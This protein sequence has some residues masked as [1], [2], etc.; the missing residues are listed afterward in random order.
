MRTCKCGCGTEVNKTWAK[1]HH[2]RQSPNRYEVDSDLGCWIWQLH[3]GSNGYGHWK[4]QGEPRPA[5][6]VMYEREVGEIL[7]GREIDHICRNRAC[8]NPE[9]LRVVTH[10]GN[11]RRKPVAKLTMEK[12]RDI[13]AIYAS[14]G[15]GQRELG[16]RYGVTLGTI[17][18]ILNGRTWKEGAV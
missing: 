12:A 15:A 13:R 16:R 14:A 4:H 10:A 18:A 17:Q 1:G 6:R 11:Q 8:V 3:V 9:H 5:H 2:T 7:E